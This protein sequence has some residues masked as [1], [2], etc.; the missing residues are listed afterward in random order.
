MLGGVRDRGLF[1]AWIA[2]L[3][4]LALPAGAS[5][6]TIN[7]STGADELDG[8]PDATCSLRE[9]IESA[10]TNGAVGGCDPGGAGADTIVLDG[11][12]VYSRTLTGSNENL[13]AT[14][15]L[16]IIGEPV[17]I[18]VSGPGQTVIAGDSTAAGDRV[19][20]NVAIGTVI[21]GVEIV[22]GQT[23]TSQGGGGIRNAGT[24]TLRNSAVIQNTAA[25]FGGGIANSDGDTLT[26]TNVTIFNNQAGQTGGGIDTDSGSDIVLNNVSIVGNSMADS[27]A[28][29]DSGGGIFAF[30]VGTA[31]TLSNSIVE[32]NT[33]TGMTPHPADCDANFPTITSQGYNLIGTIV[34]CPFTPVTGDLTE[35]SA[36]LGALSDNGGGSRT[37]AF[38]SSSPAFNAG[39]DVLAPGSG[40]AAC[41]GTDQRGVT[42]PQEGRCDIGAFELDIP[43]AIPPTPIPVCGNC[44]VRPA[45]KPKPKCRKK[46]GTKAAASAK[47]KGCKKP[48]KRK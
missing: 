18:Q 45:P 33:E 42:R 48:K 21:D 30:G 39:N 46:K 13:N 29:S 37:L 6:A 43:A 38:D 4:A 26:A 1:A 17:T 12:E 10:N 9:A 40:G 7:V 20:E 16:D 31:V 22:G 27:L 32:G 19:I 2:A 25:S 15:D 34:G 14:G 3:V 23:P 8:A 5:G 11:G 47:R 24:L 36:G 35:T 44:G 28:Q 41:A